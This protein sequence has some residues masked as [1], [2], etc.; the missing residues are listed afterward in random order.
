MKN[1]LRECVNCNKFN[2]RTLLPPPTPDLPK[3]R[4]SYDVPFEVAG[5]DYADPV[6]VKKIQEKT[7]NKYCILL[8]TCAASRCV[9]LELTTDL[10]SVPLIL[11]LRRF[12]VRRGLSK[13][14]ISDNFTT[15]F[16]SSD[17]KAYLRNSNIR[18]Q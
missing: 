10:S 1:I 4:V 6:F 14:F 9:H 16:K 5:I 17:V 11:V 18:W 15:S 8:I 3:Y 12:T 13:L 7:R 2:N